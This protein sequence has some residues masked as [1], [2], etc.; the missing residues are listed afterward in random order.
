MRMHRAFRGLVLAALA[1]GGGAAVASTAQVAPVPPPAEQQTA[2]CTAPVFATDQ[3]VC[4]DPDL[5]ALDTQ[6]AEALARATEPVS[7][8]I[9]PQGQWFLRRS[10]CAFSEDHAG[11]AEAAYRERLS[12]F[13]PP[14]PDARLLQARCDDPDIVAISVSPERIVLFGRGGKVLGVAQDALAKDKW[15]PFLVTLRRDSRILM[16]TAL[17]DTLKCRPGNRL[18]EQS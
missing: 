9:E 18:A 7:K 3:L 6:L 17:S 13:H 2:D 11:C 14:D 1:V 16:R 12:L 4:S 10:R 8:W 15:Q 5:R